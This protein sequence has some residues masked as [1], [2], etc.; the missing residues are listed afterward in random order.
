MIL[1][2]HLSDT[3]LD[4]SAAR[5]ARLR[6]VMTQVAGLARP[7]DAVVVTGDVADHGHAEEYAEARALLAA[8]VPVLTCPGNHDARAAFRASY[9]GVPGNDDAAPVNQVWALPGLTVALCDTSVPGRDDG[10][11]A[12]ET[13]DWLDEALGAAAADVPAVVGFHHPPVPLHVPFVDDIR[14]GGAQRL[15]SLLT[16]HPQVVAVLCGHAHTP[17]ATTFAG[18]PLLAAPG[19]VSTLRFPWEPGED[20]LDYTLPPA[21]AYHVIDGTGVTTHYR[22][23][24]TD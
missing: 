19:V 18:R 5:A 13:L 20:V 2:A 12:D 4:G 1:L 14:Q 11:L 7:P 9:L 16:R 23:V 8:D 17:A 10:Y 22:A 21:L 24:L 6:A 3:H 15:E